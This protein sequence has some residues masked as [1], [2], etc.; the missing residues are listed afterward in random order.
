MC[1]SDVIEGAQ[2]QMS[3]SIPSNAARALPSRNRPTVEILK[4]ALRAAGLSVSG[5]K[6]VLI[7]RC[8]ANGIDPDTLG[9]ARV[10]GEVQAGSGSRGS[11]QRA[12][13]GV[14][15]SG[16]DAAGWT[17]VEIDDAC[18]YEVAE[19]ADHVEPWQVGVR[20]VA[21]D[22][23]N[24][25]SQLRS[26]DVGHYHS[27]QVLLYAYLMDPFAAKIRQESNAVLAARGDSEG[28]SG[29]ELASYIG[30][31]LRR[32][33]MVVSD[34]VR[35]PIVTSDAHEVFPL[36][37]HKDI[38]KNLHCLPVPSSTGAQWNDVLAAQHHQKTVE[39][40]INGELR[41]LTSSFKVRTLD[42]DVLTMK[43]KQAW[44]CGTQSS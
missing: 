14:K 21:E 29:E 26:C 18:V 12:T 43:S 37:A 38:G 28:I 3:S 40:L 19:V 22:V 6:E 1:L 17:L 13:P 25:L 44:S 33:L 20:G 31:E 32:N 4:E 8:R 23:D 36:K 41:P 2:T 24:K 35:W 42:D 9:D 11:S 34:D 27:D 5:K 15:I 39:E 30:H 10:Q 7:D 16:S